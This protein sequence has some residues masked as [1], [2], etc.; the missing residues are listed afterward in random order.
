MFDDFDDNDPAGDDF[1]NNVD[2]DE[3]LQKFHLLGN[4]QSVFFSEEEIEALSYHFFLNNQPEEQMTIIEHGL[5]LFPNKVDFLVE[6]ASI[7]SMKSAH[8]EALEIVRQAKAAEPYNSIVHKMEAEILIDLDLSEEAE[9][10][11]ILAIEFSEFEDDDFVVDIYVN[12]A[13][14]LSNNSQP[15]KANKIVEKGLK[16]FPDNEQLYNQLS[17][18][19]ISNSQYDKGIIYFKKQIDDNPYAYLSWYHLGRFYELTNQHDLALSAYEY[20]GLANADS[21]NAFFNMG[22]IYE[23]RGNYNKAIDNYVNSVKNEGD[24]YP[25]ICIA[26]CYLAIEDGAMA[27]MYIKKAANLEQI[28]PEYNY[29]IGYSYLTDKTPLKALPYFKKV[30]KEDIEDFTALKGIFTCYAELNNDNEFEALYQEQMDTN[31]DLLMINWKEMASVLY[32]SESDN[33]LE[34]FLLEVKANK[35]MDN[36]LEGVLICIKYDQ[37]PSESNKDSIISRLIN[38]F[39]DTL[40]SVKLFC[41]ELYENDEFMKI[42]SIYQTDNE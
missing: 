8:S 26:R 29:L 35:R 41:T 40:E 9:E 6:K 36:E 24:L 14:L 3:T 30:F 25:Y 1:Y 13:Q 37:E 15:E 5:Y 11:F 33:L 20:S 21:K 23:S 34:Q 4:D 42:V 19:F 38:Q 27:R 7:L 10:S 22:G 18:N 39:D 12:Y 17:L 28:L 31:Y 2:I 32:H 16:R